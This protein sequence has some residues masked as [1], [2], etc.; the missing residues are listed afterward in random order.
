[1]SANGLTRI[2]F[3]DMRK[4]FDTV[5]RDA[6]F[7]KLLEQGI[8]GNF[9]NII[10]NMYEKSNVCV[11]LTVGM[12]DNFKTNIGVKQGCVISPTLFNI[13]LNDLPDI[14]KS[15]ESCPVQLNGKFLSCLMYADDIAIIS[16]TKEGLQHCL[17]QLNG[18][19]EIWKL[20]I[21]T[22]KTK[23]IVFNKTG[24]INNDETF[25]INNKE[26]EVVKEMKYLGIVFNNNGSF[27]SA[28]ANLKGKAIKALF[29]LF[30]SFSNT[31]PDIKTAKHLFDAM[32]KPILLY[33][34]EIWGSTVCDTNNYSREN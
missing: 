4:A 25:I 31:T 23:I 6:L 18:Y 24:K 20:N 22:D 21:N 3:V 5:W 32:I 16:Q 7:Y 9:Y 27:K 19:C 2:C 26:I 13:F 15:N 34:S 10:V 29:K 11:K 33:N 17:N 1:M 12:T 28:I 30:K 14:L 8:G